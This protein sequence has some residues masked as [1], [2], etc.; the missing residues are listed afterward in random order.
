[1]QPSLHRHIFFLSLLFSFIAND[2][3]AQNNCGCQEA[4]QL[5][6]SM[7]MYFN[8]GKLDSAEF[9]AKKLLSFKEAGCKIF[10]PG[11]M[12]QIALAKK[13][14]TGA[15]AYLAEE[16]KL[17]KQNACNPDLYIRH[18]STAAKLYQE[19]NLFDSVVINCLSG[20]EASQHAKDFY[21]L[22]RANADMAAAFSQMGQNEK[23]VYYYREAMA[24]ASI[25]NKVPSLVAT[26]ETRL[27]TE[28][29]SLYTKKKLQV[30][31]DS[32]AMLAK[33]AMTIAEKNKDLITF[34]EANEAM[35]NN[36]LEAGNYNEV[37]KFADVMINASPK[38]VHLFDRH[39]YTGYAK[40]SEA[41]F[42]LHNFLPAEQ[43]ADSALVYAQAF[44]PQ[45]MITAYDKVYQAARANNNAAKA[46]TAYE[47]MGALQD[48]LFSL[49]KNT[50]ITELE[51]KYNQE[52]NERKITEL[53]Q[54][55]RMYLLLAIAGLLGLAAL[56]FFLRQ[57]SLKSKQK[58][59]ETEQRLNRAR[60]NPHFFFNALGSLQG[61]ALKEND[62]KA[63][64]TNLS[65][66][67]HIMRETLES[68]Y[69]EYVTIEQETD[70]LNEYLEL[71]KI[72]FPQKFTY[73][74]NVANDMEPHELL[75]PSMII[76]PFAENSIEHGFAGIDYA[77]ILLIN[78]TKNNNEIKIE[79]SDNG[80]GFGAA[81]KNTAGHI[82]RASQII[83]DRIYLLNRKLKS[84]A[85]YSIENNTAGKG[86]LVQIFLPVIL[87]HENTDNR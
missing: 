43:F 86:I 85:R 10:F 32:A 63:I 80:A 23:A 54:Q 62:G 4:E 65:R 15:R 25:Q 11:W 6:G 28:Y 77:G 81:S 44:N 1:M 37:I 67:S 39:I 66:F 79:V 17:L 52:K 36:S 70:F 75:I 58:I 51:R 22:S 47:Q 30:Y 34:L 18:Y 13:D 46:L 16:Q 53:A 27:S 56:G 21:G 73:E 83:K 35:A 50:A 78:F 2:G 7:G 45:M 49:E 69:K 61:F 72:R 41:Y 82:S 38:G 84:K 64:A 59:L 48:S 68:S 14:F 42:K 33:D 19:L 3:Y 31:I 12:A 20:I 29:L 74:I 57:Q 71:Q 9:V 76:Q 87:Q 5:R 24:A 8:A 40:K 55:K 26:V 60:M